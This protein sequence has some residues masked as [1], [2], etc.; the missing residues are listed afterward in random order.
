MIMLDGLNRVSD[1]FNSQEDTDDQSMGNRNFS[2]YT[3]NFTA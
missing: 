1:Y 2:S 3:T